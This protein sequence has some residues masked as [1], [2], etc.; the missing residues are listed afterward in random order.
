MRIMLRMML[1]SLSIAAL[2]AGSALAGNV[3][4][5]ND[6]DAGTPAVADEV[7]AN[8]EAVRKEVN[9]NNTR[10]SANTTNKQNRV[11]GTC[12]TGQSIRIISE[13]GS[14]TCQ[15][16]TNS[17]GDITAVIAGSYL[18]GGGSSG[19][20]TLSVAGMP[21]IDWEERGSVYITTTDTVL[22]SK[23]ITAPMSGYILA[24]YG[25]YARFG[26]SS[27]TAQNMRLWM[28]TDGSS[29]MA[30]RSYRFFY[31]NSSLPSG[32]YYQNASCFQFFRVES[33][34][35]VTVYAVADG[36]EPSGSTNTRLS[37]NS[38]NLLYFPRAY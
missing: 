6:F 38:L 8:F 21:G 2:C 18:S 19:S 32:E 25:G 23:T 37:S 12:P 35:S 7:D 16:D 33:A 30:G 26:H 17:G 9:D 36:S 27:G 15:A 29:T 24:I 10:I 22:L 1:T 5:P 31:V 4:I 11:T 14:V 28:N 20:V 3:T 13:D 34:G